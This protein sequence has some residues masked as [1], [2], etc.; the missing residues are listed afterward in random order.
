MTL[1]F[2]ADSSF[3][4]SSQRFTGLIRV[5]DTGVSPA[6]GGG[7]WYVDVLSSQWRGRRLSSCSQ[8]WQA[9]PPIGGPPA[10]LS[11][12]DI[13][14]LLA[15]EEPYAFL[16]GRLISAGLVEAGGCPNNGV[17]ANGYADAC[18][19]EKALPQVLEWQNQFDA[20]IIEVARETGI[21]AQLL[22]NLIAQ[23]SQFWP[24]M[25]NSDH[26]GLGHLTEQGVE[27]LL[28][29]NPSFFDQF[30][31]LVLEESAC[32]RGYLYLEETERALLRG[33]LAS[34]AKADCTTCPTGI[35]LANANLN[36]GLLAQTLLANCEQVA[37]VVFNATDAIPGEVSGYEDLWRFTLANYHAGPG[38]LSYALYSAADLGDPLE[39]EGITQ[40][41]TPVCQGVE[42]YVNQ[43]SK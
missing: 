4:D 37:Q 42:S 23:E 41:F 35:D 14:E 12:P 16:A 13:P 40:Y 38:C 8:T 15:T 25:F 9:F 11:T 24:G 36:I 26:L 22:K 20:R 18:G 2:W 34:Q 3:G 43:I 33:A 29:W 19:L 1:E 7:G 17:L 10:W 21:P 32:E 30:C 39:W 28:L 5:I 31:R 6:P 27:P